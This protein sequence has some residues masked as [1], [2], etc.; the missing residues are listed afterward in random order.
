MTRIGVIGH[1][2]VSPDSVPMIQARLRRLLVAK[3]G[4]RLVG[5]SC[6]APGADQLFAQTVL[7][8]SGRLEVILPA[9]DY[10]GSW[11]GP[12]NAETFDRLLD[13]A[14]TVRVMG[15]QATCRQAYLAAGTAMLATV[16]TLV[17]IWDGQPAK[18]VGS[19]AAVVYAAA[20]LGLPTSV[21]WPPGATRSRPGAAGADGAP[22]RTERPARPTDGVAGGTDLGTGL[23]DSVD[24]ATS[25]AP[26]K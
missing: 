4:P 24:G 26:A 16:E 2:D 15:F 21:V 3:A 20:R 10:R 13:A 22:P 17:A 23:A 1:R 7:D 5:V 25:A 11:V 18:R 19:T 9:A 6:L 12:D 8:L 14:V